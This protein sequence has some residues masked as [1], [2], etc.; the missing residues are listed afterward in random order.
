ML[1]VVI[2]A[3]H[4]V[5][6]ALVA[7]PVVV[8]EAQGTLI[9]GIA[10]AVHVVVPE[11]GQDLLHLCGGDV[12]AVSQ[13]GSGQTGNGTGLNGGL[14]PDLVQEQ[15][16]GILQQTHLLN[17]GQGV[18]LAV[19][20]IDQLSLDVRTLLQ[21]LGEVGHILQIVADGNQDLSL[22]VLDDLAGGHTGMVDGIGAI[23]GVAEDQVLLLGIDGLGDILPEHID[24]G[25]GEQVLHDLHII[26]VQ[27]RSVLGRINAEGK[28]LGTLL[29]DDGGGSIG[30]LEAIVSNQ[31]VDTG[32]LLLG[33][34]STA[35]AAHQGQQHSGKNQ[36]R[37]QFFHVCFLLLFYYSFREPIMT[38]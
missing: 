26:V 24:I 14:C 34:F 9:G 8:N 2:Q 3:E 29:V 16:V 35:A 33:G 13:I 27:C 17:A 37:N 6:V 30:P 1:Q 25:A 21:D 5:Q 20:H 32:T 15:Q 10:V 19:L 4:T 22:G 7:L 38:P 23:I 11:I 36:N 12:D 31:A 28:L 18:D